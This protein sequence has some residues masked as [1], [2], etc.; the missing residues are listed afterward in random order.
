[1]IER[2]TQD[3]VILCGDF[4]LVLDPAKDTKNYLNIN[5]PKSHSGVLD[6]IDSQKLIDTFRYLNPNKIRF[7][8]RRKNPIKQARL[9][10]FIVSETLMDHIDQCDIIPGYRSDH[11]II[12]LKLTIN[13]FERGKGTW[14]LNSTV[15]ENK[16][17]IDMI[18]NLIKS[19]VLKYALMV[20]EIEYLEN[21]EN[22]GNI[23]FKIDDHLFLETLLLTIRGETI[24]FSSNLKCLNEQL[25]KLII[26][27]IE[28]LEYSNQNETLLKDKK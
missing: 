13:K 16:T 22:F 1:M 21:F 14:K 15:L 26:K 10:Y 20:Y 4:N 12:Q 7:S 5:N 8:W 23:Q 11:S 19:E 28:I 25:E 9:D 24:K 17:Y 27:D 3:H 18:N 2:S 6:V